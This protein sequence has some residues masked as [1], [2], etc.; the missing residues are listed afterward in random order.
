MRP[1]YLPSHSIGI[2]GQGGSLLHTH[3]SSQFRAAAREARAHRSHGYAERLS[4]LLIGKIFQG[5]EQDDLSIPDWQ[6]SHGSVQVAQ[7]KRGRCVVHRSEV[8][9]KFFNIKPEVS[10]YR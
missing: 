9:V 4:G 10:A 5:N 3:Q 7:L 1:A 6:L 8:V 2:S